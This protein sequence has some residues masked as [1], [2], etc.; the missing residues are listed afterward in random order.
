MGL[1]LISNEPLLERE[2]GCMMLLTP[3]TWMTTTEGP[4]AIVYEA[5]IA[6]VARRPTRD[7]D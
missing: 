6:F 3:Q 4:F 7:D 1:R 2:R 5:D